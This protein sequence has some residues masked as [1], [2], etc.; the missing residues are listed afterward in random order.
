MF[1]ENV[2]RPP[3]LSS[4][5]HDDEINTELLWEFKQLNPVYKVFIAFLNLKGFDDENLSPYAG[6]AFVEALMRRVASFVEAERDCVKQILF[7]LFEMAVYLRKSILQNTINSLVAVCGGH[8]MATD[9]SV[10]ELLELFKMLMCHGL[11]DSPTIIT[12][13]WNLST[14]QPI[15]H[16]L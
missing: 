10:K 13:N 11:V 2:F 8:A 4:S 15:I 7:R 1:S 9:G 16:R 14:H 6:N 5:E 12:V 3:P